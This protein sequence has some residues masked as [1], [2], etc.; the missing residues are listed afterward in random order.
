MKPRSTDPFPDAVAGFVASVW[1]GM[2]VGVSF[3][4]TLAKF[5]AASLDPAVAVEVGRRT[6]AVFTKVEW[7]LATL[8]G[9]AV[10]FPRAPRAEIVFTAITV[11]IV[12]VQALWLLPVLDLRVEAL[13]SGRPMPS[14]PHHMLYAVLEA[15]KVLTL[16][17][18]ALVALF[19]L[20]WRDKPEIDGDNQ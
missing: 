18:V 2:I 3:L 20:G 8:L 7:G 5:Q 6:F 10:F 14:S 1:L 17:A 15:G 4:A 12:A 16:A 19:R 13:I 11:A 9:I